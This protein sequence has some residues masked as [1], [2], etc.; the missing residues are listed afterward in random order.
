MLAVSVSGSLAS[1]MLVSLS[2]PARPAHYNGHV[3]A[4]RTVASRL[5]CPRDSPAKNTA[6]GFISSSSGSSRPR[7]QIHVLSLLR[8]QVGFFYH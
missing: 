1:T 8:W 4:S 2:L 5:L 6:V 3:L 7:D